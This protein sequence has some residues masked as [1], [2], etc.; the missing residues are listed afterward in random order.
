MNVAIAKPFFDGS[1]ERAVADVLRSGWVSQGRKV[2]EFERAVADFVGVPHARAVNSGTSALHLLLLALGVGPGDEVIV[3]AFTCVATLNPI[4]QVGATPV[5]V[6]IDLETFGMDPGQLARAFSA[7]TRAIIIVHLFGLPARVEAAQSAAAA[8]GIPVIE[9]AALGFAGRIG[10]RQVGTFG[11]AAFLSFH[12]RK[13]ITTGEGGMVLTR[14]AALA[15]KVAALRN[16]GASVAATERHAAALYDLP[17]YPYAGLNC[18]LTDVQAAIGCEQMRKLPEILER[19][20][21][22]A[23]VY[24]A[25]LADLP[26]ISLPAA[27][28]GRTH[29]FQSY[30]CMLRQEHVHRRA[31]LFRHLQ[32]CGVASVQGAQAI[33]TTEYYQRRYGWQAELHPAALY[34]DRATFCLPIYPGLPEAEQRQ[35]IEAVRSFPVTHERSAAS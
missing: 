12:P 23:G 14:S 31:A 25:A 27:L 7:R 20:R 17:E 19:R 11:D 13:M 18:K 24:T 30:T 3:P 1:E 29:V 35:V 26:W 6:D 28:P 32:E 2:Q 10:E 16:Y 5:P 4:E 15:E 21:R 9:D 33:A 34:A 22:I 8:A